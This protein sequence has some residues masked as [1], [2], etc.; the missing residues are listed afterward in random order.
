[1]TVGIMLLVIKSNF[2]KDYLINHQI[3]PFKSVIFKSP[4]FIIQY[5]KYPISNKTLE[6]KHTIKL[7]KQSDLLTK[8]IIMVNLPKLPENYSYINKL[9]HHLINEYEIE[10]NGKIIDKRNGEW[11]EIKSQMENNIL[12]KKMI[13]DDDN[14]FFDNNSKTIFI[15]LDFWFT[16]NYQSALPIVSLSK[17]DI[18]IN[19]KFNN[20]KDIILST[21]EEYPKI[22]LSTFLITEE[23]LLDLTEREY[24][25]NKEH[26]YLIN[27]LQYF[28]K[29]INQK[30]L[31]IP[32]DFHSPLKQIF[33]TF[34]NYQKIKNNYNQIIYHQKFNYISNHH[35]TTIIINNMEIIPEFPSSFYH[36]LIPYLRNQFSNNINTYSFNIDNHGSIDLSKI[37]KNFLKLSNLSNV[38]QINLYALNFNIIIIKDGLFL[39]IK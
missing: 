4:N 8:L 20:I 13:N 1:M 14:F 16:Q 6:S 22:S 10:I 30:N 34:P 32:I 7:K 12:Y 35:L 15:P 3:N 31:L 28:T 19:L 36:L 2:E 21:N 24:F 26:Q 37:E 18:H 25:I 33:W 29:S 38:N 11:L 9:G 23:I 27:Q 5:F 39:L 17:S